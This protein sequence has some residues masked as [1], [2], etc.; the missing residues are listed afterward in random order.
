[1]WYVVA[2]IVPLLLAGAIP[3]LH[4]EHYSTVLRAADTVI[5]VCCRHFPPLRNNQ[6][7]K[8][9][10]R[11]RRG[12]RTRAGGRQGDEDC[13]ARNCETLGQTS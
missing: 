11:S 7:P 13:N 9:F 6:V 2:A 5:V 3:V 4:R 10:T 1:M 12:L 8:E